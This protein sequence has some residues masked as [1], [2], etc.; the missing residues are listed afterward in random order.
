MG[1]YVMFERVLHGSN[2]ERRSPYPTSEL[3]DAGVGDRRAGLGWTQVETFVAGLERTRQMLEGHRRGFEGDQLD[4]AIGEPPGIPLESAHQAILTAGQDAVGVR[5]EPSAKLSND[6]RG[7]RVDRDNITTQ[8]H[9]G[10][11]AQTHKASDHAG[12]GSEEQSHREGTRSP[13]DL[14]PLRLREPGA[15][16]SGLWR[17]TLAADSDLDRNGPG[18]HFGAERVDEVPGAGS[19]AV[20]AVGDVD[21]KNRRGKKLATLSDHVRADLSGLGGSSERG[22]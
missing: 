15:K 13:I 18:S 22:A 17:A 12:A 10:S 14:I 19:G 16:R 21:A 2:R 1:L 7:C 8:R 5:E 20:V 11:P 6:D 4:G 9:G 3:K